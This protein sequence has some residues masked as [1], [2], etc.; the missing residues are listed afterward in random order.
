M[1]MN[2]H[3]TT[4]ILLMFAVGCA[5]GKTEVELRSYSEAGVDQPLLTGVYDVFE[6]RVTQRGRTLPLKI[7]VIP[8][9]NPHPEQGPIFAL[10]GGPGETATEA[11][12]YFIN[13]GLNRN[14]DVVLVDERGT[15][16]G[17]RLDCLPTADEDS[18][19]YYL[20]FSSYPNAARRFSACAETLG[21]KFDL[22]QYTT[23]AFVDDLDEV[24]QA[25]GYEVI[26]LFAGSFG[27]YAAQMYMRRHGQHVRSAYLCSLV[28]LSN[29]VPLY[30]AWGAQYA[31]EMLFD[32]WER[33]TQTRAVYPHL[34][35]HFYAI[36]SR[37][38]ARPAVTPTVDPSTGEVT[39]LTLT[40]PAFADSVRVLMYSS[41]SARELPYLIEQ[42]YAGDYRRFAEAGLNAVR[43]MLSNI[44]M[45][46]HFA[47]TCNEFVK[48]I[49]P[50]EIAPATEHSFFGSWRLRTQIGI[51]ERW[52]K[53]N[54]PANW[55][56][57]FELDAPIVIVSGERDPGSPPRWAFEALQYM[58]NAVHVIV[59]GGGHMP[60]NT[61]LRLIRDQLFETGRTVDLDLGCVD[62]LESP[63]FEA[64]GGAQHSL[65]QKTQGD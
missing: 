18:L 60:E 33:N 51:C 13:L 56:D 8:A 6:D 34:R 50:E 19:Q 62:R 48:R 36:L 21:Q 5:H 17:H 42:A 7:V 57:A 35:E 44:R 63:P 41:E 39:N 16:V 43:D 52:P 40:E 46:L 61:C 54:L 38:R 15:G 58:P 9:R 45:G 12:T 65:S 24:R 30:H 28:S 26:N 25:M 31:L 4:I 55:F 11:V 49:H 1:E 47:I 3:A 59:P 27:T 22:N 37:L 29:R 10:L 53:T 23:A 14:H 2:T 64:P 32:D 20:D